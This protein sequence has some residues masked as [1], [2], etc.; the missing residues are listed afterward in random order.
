MKKIPIIV[1]VALAVSAFFI[2]G[3]D[4]MKPVFA[5]DEKGFRVIDSDKNEVIEESSNF[6]SKKEVGEEIIFTLRKNTKIN[7][8]PVS[9]GDEVIVS[10]HKEGEQE[11]AAAASELILNHSESN[12]DIIIE[13]ILIEDKNMIDKEKIRM[14]FDDEVPVINSIQNNTGDSGWSN[15]KI[16]VSGTFSDSSH[17]YG[18]S[19]VS[20]IVWSKGKELSDAE[21]LVEEINMINIENTTEFCLES[22]DSD[23]DTKYY[24]YAVDKSDNVSFPAIADIKIDKKNPG[25][26]MEKKDSR[27]YDENGL[28]LYPKDVDISVTASDEDSGINEIEWQVVSPYDTGNNQTGRIYAQNKKIPLK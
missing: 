1:I 5:L 7:I 11:T 4:F 13:S 10:W 18:N 27:Y 26:S 17:P 24:I 20:R 19:G 14:V 15:S 9:I 8:A 3:S 21:V 12:K 22:D 28:V 23:Q 6:I 25:I 16:T 2:F